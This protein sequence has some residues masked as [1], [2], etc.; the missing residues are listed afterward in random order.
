MDNEKIVT[1]DGSNT[2]FSKEFGCAYR[3][4]HGA[5]D[6]CQHVYINAGL[7]HQSEKQTEINVLEIGFGTGLVAFMAFL[8][9]QNRNLKV[10]YTGYEGY[11]I[12][13]S[14]AES[15]Q[16]P[17]L[18]SA[19]KNEETFSFF[20]T[21]NWD[22]QHQVN[23]NFSFL[24][25]L[26]KFEDLNEINTFDV[27]FFD[28]FAPNANPYLWSDVYLSKIYASMKNNGVLT[29]YCAQGEAKRAMKRAGFSVERL[30]GANRKREMTRAT[31]N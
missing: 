27:V 17:T 16:Y 9:T 5:V 31:K 24:K 7:L 18:L 6:E 1:S 23:A 28:P 10:N 29:T 4:V 20:H 26:A 14:E 13:L 19:E 2:L 30:P 21:S 15:L 3:S 11:P 12:S 25:K 8:E 22:Q